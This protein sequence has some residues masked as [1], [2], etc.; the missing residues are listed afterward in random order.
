MIINKFFWFAIV[1]ILCDNCPISEVREFTIN[2]FWVIQ[3]Y[4]CIDNNSEIIKEKKWIKWI[5]NSKR[6]EKI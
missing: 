3:D 6:Y 4:N 1:P 5:G 2:E